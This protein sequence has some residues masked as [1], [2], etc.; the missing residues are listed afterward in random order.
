MIGGTNSSDAVY[1]VQKEPR[2]STWKFVSMAVSAG[3]ES[4]QKITQRSLQLN[5]HYIN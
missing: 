1:L 3:A 5:W 2:Q 4:I